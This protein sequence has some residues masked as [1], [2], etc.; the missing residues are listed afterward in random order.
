MLPGCCSDKDHQT[1]C[2]VKIPAL[3]AREG[4]DM[5]HLFVKQI[6][7]QMMRNLDISMQENSR[8][9]MLAIREPLVPKAISALF[10]LGVQ[11]GT[12]KKIRT[13]KFAFAF[14]NLRLF[15]IDAFLQ[16]KKLFTTQDCLS[17]WF[18]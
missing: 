17:S 13:G 11:P 14:L 7:R 8:Q 5:R 6:L 9:Q 15:L 12:T 3:R 18:I 2:Q 16:T 4:I 10:V 1:A